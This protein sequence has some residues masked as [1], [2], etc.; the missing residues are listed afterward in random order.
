MNA[1]YMQKKTTSANWISHTIY[2]L[3]FIYGQTGQK[4]YGNF[5]QHKKRMSSMWT[6]AWATA[7]KQTKCIASLYNLIYSNKI[8]DT[9]VLKAYLT[10]AIGNVRVIR[11]VYSNAV[12][13]HPEWFFHFWLLFVIC[14]YCRN[15]IH[16][17]C[18]LYV[19]LV[20]L[21]CT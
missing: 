5:I 18:K 17:D 12:K 15:K 11:Y 7:A 4:W 3:Q 19:F 21:Y 16:F 10:C 8:R 14:Y 6:K 9:E 1:S 20:W 13:K 2:L